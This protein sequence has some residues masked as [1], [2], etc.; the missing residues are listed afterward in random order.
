ME[1]QPKTGED[2]LRS[3]AQGWL[4]KIELSLKHKRPFSE[5]AAEAMSFF[6]GPH[7][8][9]WKDSYARHENGPASTIAPPAFRMQCNRVFEAVKLFGSVM[10]HRNPVR[11]VTPAKYPFITP[12]SVGVMDE[13]AMQMYQMAAQ[14]TL[15]KSD[16][17]KTVALLMERYLN[18]TPNECDLKT[19]SR[20]VVDEGIIK[21]MGVWWT[22]LV[23]SPGGG[24][25]V[26]GSFADS[27]DNFTMDPDATEIE[28][29]TWCA[30]RCVHPIDVVAAK[31]G[32]DRDVLKKHLEG[33]SPIE[34]IGEGGVFSDSEYPYKGRRVGKSNELVTYWKIWSKTGLGDRLKDAPK[35]LVGTFD[36][37]GQN[38]YIV[39]CEGVPFPLNMSPALL[40]QPVAEEAGVPDE[41]FRAVQWPIPFWAE[42]NGWPFVGLDFHRKPGY[43]WPISHIKPG[44]G[45]LR[46]INF[47]LS[48][49]AQRVATSCETI[50][51]V[52]K[53]ADQDI[54]D[55]LLAKSEK[56]FKVVE[57]SETLGRSVND[58][59]SVFQLPE[60]TPELW[61]IVDAV[62]QQFDKRVGLTELAY[63]MTSSQIRSATE[64]N[65]RAEQLSV[66][67]DDMA[68][69]L[70]DAMSLL[71]RREAFA[72]RWLLKP[73]DVEPVL[74]PLGAAVWAQHVA[75]M[76]PIEI[77]REF[78]YRI[79]AGSARKPNKA[80]RVEQMQAALQTLGPILQGLVP[81]GIV[82]PLNG[83]LTDWAESLDIDAKPY[84]IPPPPPPPPPPDPSLPAGPAGA[85]GAGG[86]PP[87]DMP[88]E[89]QP[90]PQVPPEMAP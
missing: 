71:A 80:T 89:N 64:A 30:R 73:E 41:L 20:R 55:Q 68:N 60:V 79:E 81:M 44:I 34:D 78:D 21:G 28:D 43:L 42:S 69:R 5:D 76:D 66:R 54:K 18:Y 29:I 2:A 77:A 36:G 82:D 56:G 63:A 83:L 6:D 11:T 17:R 24:P 16:I 86:P 65:V 88:P 8:W 61:K 14:E 62:A 47:A 15:Q 48:F 74:G 31:Y 27:I 12:E 23:E 51:G 25:A 33:A 32:H 46:F 85:E 13:Q 84:L 35:E 49:I 57:I 22:E 72:A 58:L 45:E 4:K 7:N 52:S 75:K 38:C 70:E 87:G 26:V 50:I 59:I 39:V 3:I 67:P 53:A 9:F 90:P 40:E 10:Y 1:S 19:H 37:L